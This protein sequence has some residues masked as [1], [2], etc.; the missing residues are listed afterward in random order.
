MHCYALCFCQN[1]QPLGHLQYPNGVYCAGITGYAAPNG[2]EYALVCKNN[3]LSIVSISHL[4]NPVEL[5]SV[6]CIPFNYAGNREVS[7]YK[8]Y[9]YV[10]SEKSDSLLVVNLNYLPDSIAWRRVSPGGITKGHTIFID[11]NGVA[12]INGANSTSGFVQYFLDLNT[13]PYNP[14]VLG[15]Y[16]EDYVHDCYVRNDTMWAACIGSGKV[17]VVDVRNKLQPYEITNWNTPLN[18][19]HNCWLSNDSR[20]LF[21]TDEQPN[22][23]LTCYDVTDLT[24]VTETCQYISDKGSNTVIHNTT[25]INNYCV[26]GYYTYGVTI[27]D[28]S[29]KNN[30]IET[31]HF[32]TSPGYSGSGFYGCWAVWP[33]LPSGNIIASDIETGL[34]VLKPTYVRA[35][36]LN[37]RVTDSDGNFINGVNVEI[38]GTNQTA[39]TNYAGRYNTG[40]GASGIFTVR[41]S[42]Q[43]YQTVTA[44]NVALTTGNTVTVNAVLQ[45]AV[46]TTV[47]IVTVDEQS[48]QPVANVQLYI[49]DTVNGYQQNYITDSNGIFKT[50]TFT[51]GLC[52]IYTG[53]WGYVTSLSLHQIAPNDTIILK[54]KKGYYDDA[55]FDL[56]W[57]VYSTATKGMWQRCVPRASYFDSTLV[58]AA[59]DIENDFGI[60][61]FATGN[62]THV[63]DYPNVDSGF[64]VLI[65]PKID[66][67]AMESPYLG[68]YWWLADT[69]CYNACLDEMSVYMLNETDT[70]KLSAKTS[71]SPQRKWIHDKIRI[72]DYIQPTDNMHLLF[73]IS[74]TGK[75]NYVKA[76]IDKIQIAD[77]ADWQLSTGEEIQK[78]QLKFMAYPNP[79]S[80]SFTIYVD[81]LTSNNCEVEIL[82]TMGQPVL[83]QVVTNQ[84]QHITLPGTCTTGIYFARLLNNGIPAK[85]IKL[86]KT[87]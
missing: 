33:Y 37:G 16:T 1:L 27:H 55:F 46:P 39:E 64:T 14:V 38:L 72:S 13:D 23:A 86:V 45:I 31:G 57:T 42:K 53:I 3:G 30:I 26:T 8:G 15:G 81:G 78:K 61:C 85:T 49:I 22:S 75:E 63:F 11:E 2:N 43:G 40:I 87:D 67:S 58:S 69:F 18:Y 29:D 84:R 9:A 50:D 79:F 10:I 70:I 60:Q 24:N 47:T 4:Y 65:S 36:L 59:N 12:Y 80:G 19:T 28:V 82:N 77:S 74:D 51:T 66:L 56:G 48:N 52:N 5:F 83:K 20:Y 68:Y 17:R 7:Q 73:W 54:L 32:D 44:D 62:P 35:S 25:F 6:P 76:L 71:L 41:F 21:T 34:W